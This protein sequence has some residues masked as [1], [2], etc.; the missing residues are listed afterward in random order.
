MTG[1]V[2]RTAVVVVF[3]ALF[4]NVAVAAVP[5]APEALPDQWLRIDQTGWTYNMG[6]CFTDNTPGTAMFFSQTGAPGWAGIDS[7]TGVFSVS[8]PITEGKWTVTVTA[9]DDITWER[10]SASF[11]LAATGPKPRPG[12]SQVKN[13]YLETGDTVWVYG[14]LSYYTDNSSL[15]PMWYTAAGGPGWA[16]LDVNTGMFSVKDGL[17]AEEGEWQITVTAW[18]PPYYTSAASTFTLTVSPAAPDIDLTA[19]YRH[20]GG[21]AFASSTLPK[22]GNCDYDADNAFDGFAGGEPELGD[23]GGARHC[24]S[25]P[26]QT[27]SGKAWA[28]YLFP[29][30][31]VLKKIGIRNR[32]VCGLT[33]RNFAV[34]GSDDS[35]DGRNGTWEKIPFA[36]GNAT[37]SAGADPNAWHEFDL[38]NCR[39]YFFY[40]IAGPHTRHIDG[41]Y[42]IQVAEIRLNGKIEPH[43]PR[44]ADGIP[45][46]EA[47]T[48][49]PFSYPIPAGAFFDPDGDP[50]V[51]ANMAALPSW[52]SFDGLGYSGTPGDGV[53]DLTI[54]VWATDN[55]GE[56]PNWAADTFAIAVRPVFDT[57][58]DGIID[59]DE[60]Q[61]YGTDAGDPDTDGD[62][63]P[64]GDELAF[65][66]N[67][68]SADPDGDG[69]NRLQDPDSDNDGVPDGLEDANGDG[70]GDWFAFRYGVVAG[71]QPVI[72]KTYGYNTRNEIVNSES[73][74]STE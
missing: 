51:Y 44:V 6:A 11:E 30:R 67:A 37:E 36:S 26:A 70:I 58:G 61:L 68:W 24:W 69:L 74:L 35:I 41:R 12:V 18:D 47:R 72:T 20:N 19:H 3:A 42:Y 27:V 16:D 48:G 39:A 50:L 43:A 10:A 33:F 59:D 23:C 64:D 53:A 1:K 52:L 25:T 32:A 66:G 8:G 9:W 60:T 13:A 63:I 55:I 38:A 49:R 65:A 2:L 73:V 28:G 31:V 29:A 54:D 15:T 46:T 71:A 4:A 14:I 21:A 22:S 7:R 17:V 34:E 57:D 56:K 5:T 62:G 45:D 40:R